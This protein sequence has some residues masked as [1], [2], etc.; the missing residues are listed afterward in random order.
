MCN[1]LEWGGAVVLLC[2]PH[3]LRWAGSKQSF[4]LKKWVWQNYFFNCR[5][6][7][8]GRFSHL[9]VVGNYNK[10]LWP[11]LK[12]LLQGIFYLNNYFWTVSFDLPG[13]SC[14]LSTFFGSGYKTNGVLKWMPRWW[15]LFFWKG[16]QRIQNSLDCIKF[17][18]T[19]SRAC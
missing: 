4:S 5:S 13:N 19:A 17:M 6:T 1:L 12:L 8:S 18:F 10:L 11:L 2:V 16:T 9:D 3:L 15:S 14:F 7:N